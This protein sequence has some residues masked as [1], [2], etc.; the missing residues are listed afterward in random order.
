MRTTGN[1][2]RAAR[3][4][5]SSIGRTKAK[6]TDTALVAEVPVLMPAERQSGIFYRVVIVDI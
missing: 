1:I 4:T 3:Q 5:H 6:T 2:Q